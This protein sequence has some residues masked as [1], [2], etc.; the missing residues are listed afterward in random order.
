MNSNLFVMLLCTTLA[1]ASCAPVMNHS[2]VNIPDGFYHVP[3]NQPYY[4]VHENKVTPGLFPGSKKVFVYNQSDTL[5]IVAA[6]TSAPLQH[7][8]NFV[9]PFAGQNPKLVL[10]G[11]SYDI[12]VFTTPF[13][14]R[15]AA[16][17]IPAQMTTSF[18]AALYTGY[19][20]DHYSMKKINGPF[21]L[22]KYNK[23]G[24]GI[25]AFAGMGSVD[26]KP[27][28]AG[29]TITYEYE[30]FSLSY[31]IALLV[32][33]RNI[34]TGVACGFD[35]I[36]DKNGTNWIYQDKPWLGVFIGLNLN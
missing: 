21:S 2:S 17:G 11:H 19:R 6:D 32:G 34:N 1:L 5:F 15:Q 26:V 35:H 4:S 25:G 16:A 29:N 18:N 30:A 7:A 14:F 8:L 36:T 24:F 22:S 3:A 10:T 20:F 28:F 13:K 33:Y 23:T 31:G 12:D 27:E 9:Y